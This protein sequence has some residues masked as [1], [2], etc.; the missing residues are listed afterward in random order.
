MWVLVRELNVVQHRAREHVEV[1]VQGG[2]DLLLDAAI[3]AVVLQAQVLEEDSVEV[4]DPARVVGVTA[5]RSTECCTRLGLAHCALDSRRVCHH[6]LDVFAVLAVPGRG[7]DHLFVIQHLLHLCF[8]WT[9][10]GSVKDTHSGFSSH[11]I[12]QEKLD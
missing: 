12:L 10:R 6:V 11:V 1:L 2:V 3:H 8:P 9:A 7:D 5:R 4:A